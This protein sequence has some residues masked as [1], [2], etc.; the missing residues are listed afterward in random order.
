[1]NFKILDL[2]AS[3]EWNACLSK[4]PTEQ[5]DI[6][7]KPEYYSIYES[8]GDG[9]AMCFVFEND[10]G[11]AL[12][13][14]LLNSVN[15]LGY[16]LDQ[17]YFDIQGAYGY[18]GVISSS[19]SNEF[20]SEFYSAFDSFCKSHN[21]VAEFTRFHPLLENYK[22]SAENLT[23]IKDRQ[24]VLLNIES[25]I[26]EI[27]KNCYSSINRNMIRKAIKSNI[28]IRVEEE[29]SGYY[30]FYELYSE[31]MSQIK[32]LPYYYFDKN[33][34]RN[35]RQSLNKNQFLLFAELDGKVICG[36]LLMIY[37]QYAHYHL[38]CRVREF[39]RL[40]PNNLILDHAIKLAKE[41]K[42]TRFHLGG[43]LSNS[44]KDSLFKFKS[45]FS[46]TYND[47]YIGKKVHNKKVYDEIVSQWQNKFAGSFS[48]S[49]NRLLGYREIVE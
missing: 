4:L 39:S 24:T 47:F 27:S 17:E 35:F 43:G 41:Q 10:N 42:C 48:K 11:I 12:Y 3:D 44:D 7:F 21:I 49:N 28:T 37:K 1:M 40:A 14:F 45:G 19:Y 23:V 34:I 46:K 33:Y 30:K 29:E 32:A 2:S 13:P 5:Q 38:S 16:K 6:Y 18:N 31:A 15:K 22:F 9:K 36:M 8:N 26:E 20:I 25:S